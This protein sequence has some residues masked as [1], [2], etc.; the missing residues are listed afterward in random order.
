MAEAI[1][2]SQDYLTVEA[3][4]EGERHSEVRHEYFDGE[5]YAM[6]GASA[7]HE[8]VAT[9]LTVALHT[10]LR[11]KSC[12]VFKDGMKLRLTVI[13]RDVFYYPDVMVACDPIDSQPYYR[14]KPKLLI[15][16]LSDDTSKDLIEKFLAYQRIPS[17][18]EYVVVNPDPTKRE[19]QIFRRS[20]GWEP[21]ERLHDGEFTLRSV[22]LTLKVADL[23]VV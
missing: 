2:K 22:G 17:L 3:Y 10:H 23:Y 15:E 12:R 5:V 4:L 8:L 19:I 18:E 14:E 11:G 16:V 20:E 6:A 9:N 7:D 21:G 13:G 1:Y